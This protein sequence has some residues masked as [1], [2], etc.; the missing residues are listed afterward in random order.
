MRQPPLQTT[1]HSPLVFDTSTRATSPRASVGGRD[2]RQRGSA[3]GST[4]RASSWISEV[5]PPPQAPGR[6]GAQ[7]SYAV[8]ADLDERERALREGEA[9]LSAEWARLRLLADDLQEQSTALAQREAAV[10]AGGAALQALARLGMHILSGNE[11]AAAQA[12]GEV[13]EMLSQCGRCAVTSTSPVH[14]SYSSPMN[15]RTEP[16]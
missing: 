13:K 14:E 5:S 8:Q 10:S 3:F 4:P 15:G 11:S 2:Q 16:V 1:Q 6:P 12:R 7:G 9:A